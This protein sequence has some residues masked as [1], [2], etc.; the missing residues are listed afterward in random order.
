MSHLRRVLPM[1]LM[2]LL[3]VALPASA[4]AV[5][6]T[7]GIT[8]LSPNHG[9]ASGGYTIRVSA[10]T[11][12]EPVKIGGKP[13]PTQSTVVGDDFENGI[14]YYI[15]TVVVPPGT[16]GTTVDVTVGNYGGV[17]QTSNDFTYD[18]PPPPVTV[19]TTWQCG[20]IFIVGGVAPSLSIGSGTSVEVPTTPASATTISFSAPTPAL[21]DGPAY[22]VWSGTRLVGILRDGCF[23]IIGTSSK[24]PGIRGLFLTPLANESPEAGGVRVIVAVYGVTD[25]GAQLLFDGVP[26]TDTQVSPN[27]LLCLASDPFCPTGSDVRLISAIAPA[28]APGFVDLAVSSG[29]TTLV[30]QTAAADDFQY[31]ARPTIS[32]VSPKSGPLAGGN[33]IELTVDGDWIRDPQVKIGGTPATDVLVVRSTNL[34]DGTYDQRRIQATVPAGV[35]AGPVAIDVSGASGTASAQSYD[36]SPAGTADYTYEAAPLLPV[37]TSAIGG[38]GSAVVGGLILIEGK[39]LGGLKS[40]RVGARTVVILTKTPGLIFGYVPAQRAGSYP[41]TVTTRLGSSTAAAKYAFR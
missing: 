41:V 39:N 33:S 25:P 28:H 12:W 32:K 23:S 5:D 34:Y 17:T 4:S 22:P 14:A 29:G 20:D 19:P 26:G 9:D 38:P 11:V 30:G 15:Q 18:G 7:P 40:V 37:I 2:V 1:L 21:A 13:A 16:P 31:L 10:R 35:A 6:R 27:G 36:V 3:A 8:D 24:E